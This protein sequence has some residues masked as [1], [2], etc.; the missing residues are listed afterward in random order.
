MARG[1]SVKKQEESQTH[2]SNVEESIL[3]NEIITSDED[4]AV[5]SKKILRHSNYQENN[6]EQDSGKR[7]T[8]AKKSESLNNGSKWPCTSCRFLNLASTDQCVICTRWRPRLPRQTSHPVTGVHRWSFLGISDLSQTGA[9]KKA[10]EK[11]KWTCQNCKFLNVCHASECIICGCGADPGNKLS[12]VPREILSPV[13]DENGPTSRQALSRVFAKANMSSNSLVSK[14]VKLSWKCKQCRHY[15]SAHSSTCS[16]CIKLIGSSG[17]SSSS[18]LTVGY[19]IPV[20]NAITPVEEVE[21]SLMVENSLYFLGNNASALTSPDTECNRSPK[22]QISCTYGQ[23]RSKLSKSEDKP[24]Y[25]SVSSRV[26]E[27]TNSSNFDSLVVK[28]D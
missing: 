21:G 19:S 8:P 16:S 15:N 24:V 20:E 4:S 12:L 25:V 22:R 13:A 9:K 10:N 27:R 3:E 11:E 5:L 17:S 14:A 26:S 28:L 23:L 1:G 6:T 2:A 18:G 7:R